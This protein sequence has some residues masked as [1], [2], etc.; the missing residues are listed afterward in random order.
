[1]DIQKISGV[2]P[3]TAKYLNTLNIKT[4]KDAVYYYPRDYEFRGNVKNINDL[5]DGETASVI[6]EVSLIYPGRRSYS[7]KYI[8]RILFKNKTGYIIGIWFSKPYIKNNFEIGKSFF[9]YGKISKKTGEVQ[10]IEPQYEKIST[11]S[12]TLKIC[13][14]YSTN[15]YV[16][17]KFLRKV[18]SE[19]LK[20]ID[21]LAD[22]MLPESLKK[23]YNLPDIK[24]A[25]LNIHFPE[26]R[27]LLERAR[28]RIK[29][30]ELLILQLVLFIAKKSYM[31]EENAFSVP[32]C[33]EMIAF[34]ESI[35]F[36]LTGAQ[37]HAIREILSDM[38]KNKPMN[39]LLQGDVG[40]GKTIV[41]SAALFNCAA[42]GFE[43]ALMAPTE[44]LA[45]QHFE[46]I[47]SLVSRWNI[48][49]ALIT[50]STPQKEKE[51]I[52]EELSKGNIGIIIGTH[53]LIQENVE[54]KN[55][56]LVI[57]DEQHRFGVRQRAELVNKGKNP[58]VLVMTATPIPRTLALFLYGDMDISVLN[59]IPPGRQKISTYSVGPDKKD[60]IYK[61]I[62]SEVLKGNQAYI[63]CP[64]VE[65]SDKIE[66]ESAVEIERK[67]K[68]KYFKNINTGL[69]HGKMASADRD[70][71]M[72]DFK[73]GKIKVLVSTT[74][75]E[76]GVNVPNATIMVVEN[77]DRFGLAQLHQLRGR[78]G[79]GTH[80]SY[81][82]LISDLK[83]IES[84]KRM[85]I[86]VKTNDGFAIS[87]KDMEMRGTG[88]F[89]GLRQHGLP[90]LK[91]ADIFKDMDILKETHEISKEIIENNRLDTDEYAK[92]KKQIE[93][94]KEKIDSATFN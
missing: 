28:R 32:V 60:R 1:L 43:C 15:K 4:A 70:K 14:V 94:L 3:K 64:L 91:M 48:K 56:A 84:K 8:N 75:I 55:L 71:V 87:E 41:A 6:A 7:G 42:N 58:H 27:E 10:I 49:T 90:E 24:T 85:E 76:V 88:E 44:I 62:L 80:K 12:N 69:V 50:G 23:T 21:S 53:A 16:N 89:F 63:V 33:R 72:K 86:M 81:C 17:Q 73:E 30:E 67:L 20:Y 39:R 11:N 13:P 9:L 34:K 82:I 92:I 37:S 77:A 83:K 40:S 78:V 22:D 59:E 45:A 2:G 57:T 93:N 79:R 51:E 18:I 74:V 54:F 61:F 26:S 31:K 66:A 38:K 19:S 68:E 47:S 35:P 29:F 5:A 46:S 65:E 36:K 25:L 52:L